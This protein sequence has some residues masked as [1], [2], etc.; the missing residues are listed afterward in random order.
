MLTKV[1]PGQM[2]T[3]LEPFSESF[4]ATYEVIEVVSHPDGQVVCIL[5]QEAGG[6]DPKY[7]APAPDLD[8]EG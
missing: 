7:L 2:V 5:S 1:V 4:P 3:V 8:K 6:F